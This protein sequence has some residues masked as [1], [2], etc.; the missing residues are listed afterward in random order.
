M[1]YGVTGELPDGLDDE[2]VDDPLLEDDPVAPF[3]DDERT[4]SASRAI[5]QAM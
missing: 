2:S 5:S 3:N 4:F 1:S